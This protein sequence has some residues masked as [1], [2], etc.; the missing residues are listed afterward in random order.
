MFN[1]CWTPF[2]LNTIKFAELL[3]EVWVCA[4]L[5]PT[6]YDPMDCSRP[7]FSVHGIFQ[8][9]ITEWLAITYPSRVSCIGRQS[10]YHWA[11][12]ET[13]W[14]RCF[15][16]NSLFQNLVGMTKRTNKRKAARVLSK[17]GLQVRSASLPF[18][19]GWCSLRAQMTLISGHWSSSPLPPPPSAFNLQSSLI[20][21][22][23]HSSLS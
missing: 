2:L 13:L 6:L 3:D 21:E 12:W 22:G 9:R 7:C 15:T 11:T 5:Y 1:F 8:A 23:C 20:S 14:M 17:C 4:Q 19:R 16:S 10:L 18:N